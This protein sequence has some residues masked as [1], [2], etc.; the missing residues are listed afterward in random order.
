MQI[1]PPD[2]YIEYFEVILRL[3]IV[4]HIHVN[5]TE[6]KNRNLTFFSLNLIIDYNVYYYTNIAIFYIFFLVSIKYIYI[7][8]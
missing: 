6:Y 2:L 1:L 4:L 7:F 8:F 5:F 3:Y